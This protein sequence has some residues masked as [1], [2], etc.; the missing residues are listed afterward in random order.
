MKNGS[1]SLPPLFPKG[2]GVKTGASAS[3]SG[4]TAGTVYMKESIPLSHSHTNLLMMDYGSEVSEPADGVH[5]PSPSTRK[6]PR[7]NMALLVDSSLV[8]LLS[9][10][11]QMPIS[12][13]EGSLQAIKVVLETYLN[14]Y[15]SEWD[16]I[17]DDSAKGLLR[18][19][20]GW[21]ALVLKLHQCIMEVMLP[22]GTR[23]QMSNAWETSCLL[24]HLEEL[25]VN[26]G[27]VQA[28]LAEVAPLETGIPVIGVRLKET[29]TVD[30]AA[31]VVCFLDVQ[32][33]WYAVQCCGRFD[34]YLQG[35]LAEQLHASD[36]PAALLAG[37]GRELYQSGQFRNRL[38]SEQ[39]EWYLLMLSQQGSQGGVEATLRDV[40][41][42]L[43][44]ANLNPRDLSARKRIERL[45]VQ[46]MGH[47]S[48]GIR[49]KAVVLLNRFYDTHDWQ[50]DGP[51]EN[52][53]IVCV[54]DPLVIRFGGRSE[55]LAATL[56]LI[57]PPMTLDPYSAES[58]TRFRVAGRVDVSFDL[59]VRC[60]FYDW[61]LLTADETVLEM[62]RVIVQPRGARQLQICRMS[63]GLGG[64]LGSFDSVT[65]GLEELAEVGFNALHLQG[66]LARDA[67]LDVCAPI[68]R[69]S[70]CESLGGREG[71]RTLS[72]S[73]RDQ[74]M[75]AFVELGPNIAPS[76]HHRKYKSLL[77]SG[78]SLNYRTV[79][80]WDLLVA[81]V[82][83][84]P[85]QFGVSGVWLQES[86][87]PPLLELNHA[88]LLRVDADGE[89]HYS[90]EEI[91]RGVVVGSAKVPPMEFGNWSNPI[92]VKLCREIWK[93][94]VNFFIFS[95]TPTISEA[96]TMERCGVIPILT[97]L[98]PLVSAMCGQVL[99]PVDGTL[100][101]VSEE[102]ASDGLVSF[103][104]QATQSCQLAGVSS[105][106]R[107]SPLPAPLLHRARAPFTDLLFSLP[108]FPVVRFGEL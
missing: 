15:T 84:W 103:L 58:L 18:S 76:R 60:G 2:S 63:V 51:F 17:L 33:L 88:E 13:A 34:V 26:P 73:A 45:L 11:S 37:A 7:L 87:W 86:P 52:V 78:G 35:I 55:L 23:E 8:A 72:A 92:L 49:A 36:L 32:V 25:K 6:S 1:S 83:A 95:D 12:D 9:H 104:A 96:R 39:Y 50:S 68:D 44:Y 46:M 27:K 40:D 57:A 106:F 14:K 102:L 100:V 28:C 19:L 93:D 53:K 82:G 91:L 43:H 99:S 42:D 5:T 38:F 48:E 3:F 89:S 70:P 22:S 31:S 65:A 108:F 16:L 98:A 61:R 79:E 56:E 77:H 30:K 64:E 10:A 105:T 54:G 81:D 20:G 4:A 94:H 24:T 47:P 107:D 90:P 29:A 101:G 71:L 59:A 75:H 74:C 97:Q 67:T 85:S 66:V 21:K 69:A 62:G 41:L 80:A